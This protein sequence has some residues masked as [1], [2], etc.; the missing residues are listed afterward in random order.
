MRYLLSLTFLFSVLIGF[1]RTEET[2]PQILLVKSEKDD[3]LSRNQSMFIF[4]FKGLYDSKKERFID[5]S[6]DGKADRKKLS[7]NNVLRVLNSPGNHIFQFYYDENHYEIYTDSL[8]IKAQFSNTYDVYFESA[9]M[10]IMSEKPVIYLYP[11]QKTDVE[12]KIDIKGDPLYLYP[13]YND[14]WQFSATPEGELQFGKNTYNYLFWESVN[15][16]K[17]SMKMDRGFNVKGSETTEFLEKILSEAGLSSKEKADFITYWAPRMIKNEY[18][19]IRFEFNKECNQ[20]AAL[21]ITP[22][23]DEIYR[24][25]MSWQKSRP[26]VKVINQ[27]IPTMKRKGFSVLEWGGQEIKQPL[28]KSRDV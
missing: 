3:N 10:M 27:V 21:D 16:G 5:Y 20:Y 12:V 4:E 22:K 8:P 24:I 11:E 6:I 19:F 14:G 18:N 17:F 23:P 9:E 13:A 1:A 26:G 2:L 28:R 7:N 25:Y 15:K